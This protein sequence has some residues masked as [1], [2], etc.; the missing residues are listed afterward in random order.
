MLAEDLPLHRW[1]MRTWP[2]DGGGAWRAADAD[3]YEH[4]A[5]F[6]AHILERLR[7]DGPLRARDIEDRASTPVGAPAAGA[8]ERS[9]ARMLDVMWVR[10]AGRDLAAATAPSACGT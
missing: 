1:E 3:W 2:R 4:Q 7:A 5:A 6:R 8:N 9:V 10:G